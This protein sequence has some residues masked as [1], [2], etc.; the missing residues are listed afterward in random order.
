VS[1]CFVFANFD[2]PA[3]P[4]RIWEIAGLHTVEGERHK[5][6]ARQVVETALHLLR[7]QGTIPRYQIREDNVPSM[8]LAE[9]V[10]LRQFLTT[11]HFLLQGD[12]T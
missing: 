9:S 3:E 1:A 5:G 7:A 2:A 8:R 11:E 4:L 6:Y 10:G 12:K